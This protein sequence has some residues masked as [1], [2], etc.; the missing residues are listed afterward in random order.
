MQFKDKLAVVTGGASG[1]GKGVS[2]VL[3]ERGAQVALIDLNQKGLKTA[4][5]S[6]KKHNE[7]ISIFAC[8]VTDRNTL[9]KTVDL[10]ESELGPIEILVNAAGVIAAEGFEDT[11]V[12][13]IEDWDITY[14]VNVKGTVI[15]SELIAENMK[16]RRRG[17][18]VNIASHGGRRGAGGSLSA[19]TAS[20]AAVIHYTQSLAMDM[21]PHNINVNS[22]CPGTIW[23]PMWEKIAERRIRSNSKMDGMTPREVYDKF[24]EEECPM[25]KEQTSED[26]AKAVAFF[27]SEDANVITGQSLNVNGGTRMD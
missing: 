2:Q 16:P 5:S 25:K 26:I 13:R 24:I 10:I 15:A 1:I 23:T 6:L 14:T 27:A 11:L 20:K 17:K 22:V 9:A 18:I 19:Y 8:D 7:N 21:A 12:S 3:L 4:T